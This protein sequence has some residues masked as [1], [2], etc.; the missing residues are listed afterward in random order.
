MSFGGRVCFGHLGDGDEGQDDEGVEDEDFGRQVGAEFGGFAAEVV[1]GAK[2][3]QGDAGG[4]EEVSGLVDE[5]AFP[6]FAVAAHPDEKVKERKKREG[7]GEDGR[8]FEGLVGEGR[9]GVDGKAGHAP[10]EPREAKALPFP[11]PQRLETP[12]VGGRLPTF[13]PFHV[14][15]FF[16]RFGIFKAHGPGEL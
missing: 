2:A 5:I 6:C 4:E 11:L 1:S 10:K 8:F 9:D 7:E 14:F 13:F 3:T 12:G 16:G 15:A